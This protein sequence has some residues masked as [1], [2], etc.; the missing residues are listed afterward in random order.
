MEGRE[1][2]DKLRLV[3][4]IRVNWSVAENKISGTSII[5]KII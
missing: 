1:K 3:A 5:I 4:W 2:C